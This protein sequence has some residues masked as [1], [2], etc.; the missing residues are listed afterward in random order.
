MPGRVSTPFCPDVGSMTFWQAVVKKAL[1]EEESKMVAGF[2]TV[3]FVNPLR[4]WD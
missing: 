2:K 3:D 4:K 1:T